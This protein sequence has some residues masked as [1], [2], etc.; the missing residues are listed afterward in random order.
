MD[1]TVIE[2]ALEN[3][4]VKIT[5]AG[6]EFE[7]KEPGMKVERIIRA[8]YLE[9]S[10]PYQDFME[11]VAKS[12]KSKKKDKKL[13]TSASNQA[14]ELRYQNSILEWLV[15]ALGIND[16][17]IKTQVED[18]ATAKELID[19][20]L[21]IFGVLNAPLSGGAKSTAQAPKDTTPSPSG[22]ATTE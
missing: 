4:P 1:N 10:A 20:K 17:V 13:L 19:A 16:P 5:L 6:L 2:N 12:I 3:K 22:K 15:D 7:F 8:S 18:G 14:L 9:A 21:A 11:K